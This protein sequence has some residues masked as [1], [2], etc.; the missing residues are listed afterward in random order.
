MSALGFVITGIQRGGDAIKGRR[1]ALDAD[2]SAGGAGA[3]AAA[4]AG[5]TGVAAAAA[6]AAAAVLVLVVVGARTIFTLS[7]WTE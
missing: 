1:Q 6:A 3:A 5:V 4:A 7:T 2:G